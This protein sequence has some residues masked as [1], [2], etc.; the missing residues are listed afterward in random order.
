MLKN[1]LRTFVIGKVVSL[2]LI[3]TAWAVPTKVEIFAHAIAHAEGYGVAHALPTVCNNPGDLKGAKFEGQV[4]LCKGGHAR[5]KN[6]AYGWNALYNQI[7]KMISGQS[8]VYHA[9]MTFREVA[10]LYAG[11]SKRWLKNV[12]AAMGIVPEATLSLYFDIRQDYVTQSIDWT[13][14]EG[15]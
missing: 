6:A 9:S 4:G 8:R 10:R 12:C 5:F 3:G 13:F 7:D 2:L 14:W 15:L 1:F 11:D